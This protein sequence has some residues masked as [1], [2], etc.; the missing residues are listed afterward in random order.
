[1]DRRSLI[2]NA[3]IAGVLAAGVAPAVHAQAAVRWRL[4]S[5][6]PKS[7]D[8]IFGAADVFAK[9]VKAMSGGKFEISV[10]AA[11]E[12]MPAFGVVDG[13]Q[14]GSI[15][16]AHTAPYYFFGKDETFALGC[17]I[18][19]GLNSRQMT[20]WMYEGN[21][22][23][24]MREFY[25]KYNIVNFPGGNTGAQMGGWY[26]KEIKTIADM[27]GLKMRIGGFGGKVLEKLG[28]VPQNIPGGEIYQALEKG[29]IDAA[30]WVGP[31]DDQKLGFNK[32]A[33]FYYYPGWWEGGPQLDFFINN[34]AFE[35]LSPENKAI[36]ESAASHAHVEMQARYDARNPAALKQL[37]GAGTKLRPFPKDVM[38]AAFKAAMG[39]YEELNAKNESW[40]KI[41][42]DYSKF[43]ADQNLWFR[44]TEA[45]F[46]KFMQEQKLS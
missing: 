10:H 40:K 26:R 20:A 15:E 33:P 29:T 27:K 39:L 4:A 5:S 13:V 28:S 36:V 16:C 3:G 38:N 25:A 42:A 32:V 12:L 45:S 37:V 6:F 9:Q 46:D 21:G 41:Y 30:E 34:K 23:K 2:K 18:P 44:F 22:M 19:F 24:L 31:Y 35:A 14:Q 8:T 17:A 7:L 1:M 11:G 43:R